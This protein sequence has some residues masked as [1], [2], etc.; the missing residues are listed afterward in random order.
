MQ[1]IIICG[2]STH[3][4]KIHYTICGISTH[5]K[6]TSL[7]Y[8]HDMHMHFS[9]SN[10]KRVKRLAIRLIRVEVGTLMSD[11]EEIDMDTVLFICCLEEETKACEKRKLLLPPQI[12]L[13][14]PNTNPIHKFTHTT[15]FH[16]LTNNSIEPTFEKQR[17]KYSK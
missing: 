9:N 17:C 12:W 8:D 15:K 3:F 1:I 16:D 10:W 6:Y 11:G 5:F 13:S 2:I 7:H 4:K 14:V